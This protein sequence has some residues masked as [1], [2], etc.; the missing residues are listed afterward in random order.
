ME[1]S[2]FSLKEGNK[3]KTKFQDQFK[4]VFGD[5]LAERFKSYQTM[6]SDGSFSEQEFYEEFWNILMKETIK[7]MNANDNNENEIH[8]EKN[9]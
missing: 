1:D 3:F 5:V 2:Q 7:D 4:A 9:E 8:K 6:I